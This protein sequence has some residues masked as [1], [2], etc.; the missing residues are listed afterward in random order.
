MRCWPRALLGD[1]GEVVEKLGG[2]EEIMIKPSL[3]RGVSNRNLFSSDAIRAT[4]LDIGGNALRVA[5]GQLG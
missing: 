2:G 4:W 3:Q 5:T 1:F